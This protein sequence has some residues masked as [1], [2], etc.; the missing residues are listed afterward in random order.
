V[1]KTAYLPVKM[2]PEMKERLKLAARKKDRSAGWVARKYIE[3]GLDRDRIPG[4]K[5]AS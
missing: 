4:K 2:S 1:K 5:D 3:A